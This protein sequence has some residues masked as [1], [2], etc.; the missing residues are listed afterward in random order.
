MAYF[1]SKS[2]NLFF[3]LCCIPLH[4]LSGVG[5]ILTLRLYSQFYGSLPASGAAAPLGWFGDGMSCWKMSVKKFEISL[6]S[7]IPLDN[8]FW[9]FGEFFAASLMI[10]CVVSEFM[11]RLNTL[12]ESTFVDPSDTT[13]IV[14]WDW[15]D[16]D[17]CGPV[18]ILL[19]FGWVVVLFW[20]L[21]F[22]ESCV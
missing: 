19:V 20:L 16:D 12:I 10:S 4:F 11:V 6:T 15:V 18:L 5:S 21:L 22:S 7:K 2:Y 13:P 14:A 9:M 17:A 3:L 8:A 1:P